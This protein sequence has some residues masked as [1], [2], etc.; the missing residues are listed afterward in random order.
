MCAATRK[1]ARVAGQVERNSA[2]SRILTDLTTR[3][4]CSKGSLSSQRARG[5]GKMEGAVIKGLESMLWFCEAFMFHCRF[6]PA[7]RPPNP[8]RHTSR[9]RLWNE[10]IKV[11]DTVIFG[12]NSVVVWIFCFW[13][14]YPI[15]PSSAIRLSV[16]LYLLIIPVFERQS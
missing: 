5:H 14:P 13:Y 7:A 1:G 2:R 11:L 9:L 10:A 4:R 3:R 16:L 8:A 15:I 12:S 6:S